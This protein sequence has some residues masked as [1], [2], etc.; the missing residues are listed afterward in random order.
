MRAMIIAAIA[1]SA[2][3]TGNDTTIRRIAAHLSSVGHE[4]RL[5]EA[6]ALPEVLADGVG[7][8]SFDAAIV[9][10]AVAAGE[11]RHSLNVPYIVVF[12]G[13]DLNEFSLDPAHFAVM[14]EAVAGAEALVAF[15]DDFVLRCL[16]LWPDTIGKLYSIPQAVDT[17][18]SDF[19]LKNRL[20]LPD[21]SKVLLLPAGLRPVKDPLF[22]TGCVD[23][24]HREDPRVRLVIAGVSYDGFEEILRRRCLRHSGVH[25]AGALNRRDLHA[26]M[27]EATAV[28][29]TSISECSPNAVLEAMHLG[30]PVIARD[31]PGNTCLVADG[32]TGLLFH[33]PD[34][35]RKQAQR[36]LEDRSLA[37]TLAGNA[38]RMIDSRHGLPAEAAAYTQ[39]LQDVARRS[40]HA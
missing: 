31:I 21:D 14:T 13:T 34:E 1:D 10:H 16:A 5:V 3:G 22:L 24:W 11:I 19:S 26:A 35:F 40:V 8:L 20:G 36:L 37:A 28:L 39:L 32:I 29:N 2:P 25:Y 9:T 38:R 15:N 27:R 17:D 18:P 12:G 30:T 23:E 33:S 6:S 4:V 7:G